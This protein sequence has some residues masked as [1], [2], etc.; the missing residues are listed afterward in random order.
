MVDKIGGVPNPVTAMIFRHG[1]FVDKLVY[2]GDMSGAINDYCN[3]LVYG[4]SIVTMRVIG[5]KKQ[6]I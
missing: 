1:K 2:V 3:C 5:G 6:P 4:L